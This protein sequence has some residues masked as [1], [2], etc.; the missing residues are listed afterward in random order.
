MYINGVQCDTCC[1]I[2]NKDIRQYPWPKG[3]VSLQRDQQ[4]MHFCSLHCLH[5]WV[6]KQTIVANEEVSP[7]KLELWKEVK[8]VRAEMIEVERDEVNEYWR[9][10]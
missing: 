2:H 6:E 1:K 5:D 4:E 9:D 3:W 7:D 10:L 8:I